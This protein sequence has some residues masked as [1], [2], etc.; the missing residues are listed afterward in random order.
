MYEKEPIIIPQFNLLTKAK[1]EEMLTG[2]IEA[3]LDKELATFSFE[4]IDGVCSWNILVMPEFM[5]NYS[6]EASYF[7]ER[8]YDHLIELG[9]TN[10]EAWDI[11]NNDDFTHYKMH[12]ATFWEYC[13]DEWGDFN[14]VAVDKWEEA[15]EAFQ[16]DF[17]EYIKE[18][19]IYYVTGR[20]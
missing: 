5:Y 1:L 17:I 7:Q 6:D 9:M 18:I 13:G 8:Y 10:E 14:E 15:M 4:A 3:V 11:I 19:A 12:V 20:N 2:V 16:A